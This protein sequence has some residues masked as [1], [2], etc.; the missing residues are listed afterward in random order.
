MLAAYSGHAELAQSLLSHGADADRLNDR[1]QTP[2][3]GAVFKGHSEVVRVL[4]SAGANPRLGTPTAIQIARM[5]NRREMFDTLGAS[6]A[7]MQEAVPLPPLP[8]SGA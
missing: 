7:D 1:G 8:P 6:E 5:F 3:A 4:R 2:L